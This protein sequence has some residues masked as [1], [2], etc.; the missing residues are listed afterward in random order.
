MNELIYVVLS[1]YNGEQYI[2]Q[3]IDSIIQQ[4][5][6]DY[7]LLIRDDGSRD[8][9]R[10]ILKEY[11]QNDKIQVVYG[12]NLGYSKSFISLVQSVPEE[13]QYV[14]I[15]DQDDI[16]D[17]NKLACA[18]NLMRNEDKMIPLL[19]TCGRRLLVNGEIKTTEKKYIEYGFTGLTQGYAIQGCSMV[20]NRTLKRLIDL[21]SYDYMP[22]IYDALIMH[23]CKYNS[24][25][26]IC[27]CVPHFTYRI[28]NNNSIGIR[29]GG[30]QGEIKKIFSKTYSPHTDEM[31]QQLIDTYTDGIDEENYKKCCKW[32]HY[33]K[34]IKNK[35][36]IIF[37]KTI[38]KGCFRRKCKVIIEVLLNKA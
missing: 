23:I 29:S 26:V 33:K 13:A 35:M 17:S 1:S 34:S 4:K 6:V 38:L 31:C 14:A 2:Q 22:C 9:T 36:G 15:S 7:R 5:N 16:W 18:I 19:Y 30:F 10:E 12:E 11:E 37:D 28:H 27:D 3:Q 32:A 20:I 24:G 8:K 25:K 21:Y